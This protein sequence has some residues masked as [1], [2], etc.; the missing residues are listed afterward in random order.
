MKKVF[1]LL[2][3]IVFSACS[4]TIKVYE[5]DP[6]LKPY[7]DSFIA[8]GKI[9]N[10]DFSKTDNVIIQFETLQSSISTMVGSCSRLS[11]FDQKNPLYSEYLDVPV[12]R[13]DP[14]FFKNASEKARLNLI[15]HEL[16][17]CF[18][19]RSHDET[20]TI[21]GY[22]KSFMYP[23]IFFEHDNSQVMNQ[24]FEVYYVP[25][26]F[27]FPVEAI[28]PIN[29]NIKMSQD[30]ISKQLLEIKS[31]KDLD[32]SSLNETQLYKTTSNGCF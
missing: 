11:G 13:I 18:L 5:I 30:E 32:L 14:T 1:L 20:M 10:Q 2:T 28:N 12:I 22:P 21:Y 19:N 23:N 25:E 27:Y 17:H 4:K 31:V 9:N 16:G 15:F 7:Y 24:L 29:L 6:Q 26:L 3:L 8:Y